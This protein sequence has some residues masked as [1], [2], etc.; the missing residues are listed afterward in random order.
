[1]AGTAANIR[2]VVIAIIL[3]FIVYLVFIDLFNY[4][5]EFFLFASGFWPLASGSLLFGKVCQQP[6]ANGQ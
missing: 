1:M 4:T 6:V 5:F 3:F 2:T